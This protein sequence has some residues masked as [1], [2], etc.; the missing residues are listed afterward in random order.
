[1]TEPAG[2]VQK[3]LV[4]LLE[5]IQDRIL[6]SPKGTPSE[7]SELWFAVRR[8]VSKEFL[9]TLRQDPEI[10]NLSL[11]ANVEAERRRA[12]ELAARV[13]EQLRFN[14]ELAQRIQDVT[15]EREQL[16]STITAL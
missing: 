2:I 15:N 10:A 12:D 4:S 11:A 7:F 5:R 14:A 16:A 8:A 13:D 9:E 6:D 3:V 1:M